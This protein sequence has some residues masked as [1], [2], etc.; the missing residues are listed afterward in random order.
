M[1]LAQTNWLSIRWVQK[2]WPGVKLQLTGLRQQ[3]RVRNDYDPIAL[4]GR[5][6]ARKIAAG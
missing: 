3:V 6:M 2:L 5:Q 4:S 1:F